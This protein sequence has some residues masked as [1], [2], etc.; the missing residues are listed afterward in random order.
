MNEFVGG[1]YTIE[2]RLLKPNQFNGERPGSVMM[3]LRL[4]KWDLISNRPVFDYEDIIFTPNYR[5]HLEIA[6]AFDMFFNAEITGEDNYKQY[7]VKVYNEF[8][9]MNYGW[10]GSDKSKESFTLRFKN[11]APGEELKIVNLDFE[12]QPNFYMI[13]SDSNI[14]RTRQI[15]YVDYFTRA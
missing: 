11:P 4:K 15:S 7:G 5:E 14:G 2:W 9:Y 12:I 6:R 3:K 13:V 8:H 1:L 10:M